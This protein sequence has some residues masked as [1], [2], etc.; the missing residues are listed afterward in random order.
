MENRP[1]VVLQ[2]HVDMVCEKNADKEFDFE[3]DPI[4]PVVG[5]EWVS[6]NGTTLGCG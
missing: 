4:E 6:A 5:E 1:V 2:T 3:N